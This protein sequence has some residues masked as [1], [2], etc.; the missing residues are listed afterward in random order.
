MQKNRI[1]LLLILFSLFVISV[2]EFTSPTSL[3][4][5]PYMYR[6]F[7]AAEFI[8]AKENTDVSGETFSISNFFGFFGQPFLSGKKLI[9]FFQPV[10]LAVNLNLLSGLDL[11]FLFNHFYFLIFI[12]ALSFF[13]LFREIFKKDSL[14]FVLSLIVILFPF[15]PIYYKIS[16]HGWYF[17][18]IFG[19]IALYFLVKFLRSGYLVKSK[20]FFFLIFFSVLGIYSDKSAFAIV[21][22]P[23]ILFFLV[24]FFFEKK[25]ILVRKKFL[26]FFFLFFS[27]LI[28]FSVF[29]IFNQVFF[30]FDIIFYNLKNFNFIPSFL[31]P[32][33][34]FSDYYLEKDF[35]YLLIRYFIPVLTVLSLFALNFRTIKSFVFK[36][37]ITRSFVFSQTVFY[38]LIG[39]VML[40]S[41]AFISSRGA[42]MIF[43][44]LSLICFIGLNEM[45]KTFLKPLLILI[46]FLFVLIIPLVYYTQT[47]LYKYEQF[48]QKDFYSIKWVEENL[49]KDSIFYSDVKMANA[50]IAK[51]KIIGFNSYSEIKDME[52]KIIPIYFDANT[53]KV[54]EKFKKHHKHYEVTHLLLTSEMSSSGFQPANELLKPATA[55]RQFDDSNSFDKIFENKQVRIYE[56]KN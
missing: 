3:Y 5:D 47:P 2:I 27:L 18:R 14:A 28:L 23:I 16:I 6:H 11:Y 37:V 48:N 36:D 44:F 41:L 56:I 9:F 39:S 10:L 19:A 31:Q 1:L 13:I 21:L 26:N 53:E 33:L 40:L 22:M 29:N 7:D 34:P 15:E 38:L 42:S 45:K 43:L 32:N 12:V 50:V 49:N 30:N 20:N 35:F 46:F 25:Q 8:L 24:Y 4:R 51:A 17:V 55:L 52:E 54:L